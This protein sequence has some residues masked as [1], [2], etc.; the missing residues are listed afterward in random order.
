VT[1]KRLSFDLKRG[2]RRSRSVTLR[3]HGAASYRFA[4][5]ERRNGSDVPW[6][7]L[8]RATRAVVRADSTRSFTVKVDSHRLARRHVY[9]ATLV[10]TTTDPRTPRI[11]VPVTV[12]V[13]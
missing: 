6:L 1:P 3:N 2:Q 11:L 7:R 5:A 10:V 9:R 13:R 4:V 8:G 12:R